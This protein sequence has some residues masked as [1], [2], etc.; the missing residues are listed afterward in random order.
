MFLANVCKMARNKYSN[1]I[2]EKIIKEY[3]SGKSQINLSEKYSIPKS[4]ICR[5]VKFYKSTKSFQ[6]VHRGGRPRKTT[7]LEDSAIIKSIKKDPFIS[8]REIRVQLDLG[9]SARTIRRRAVD[10]GLKSFKAVKKPFISTKNKLARLKFAHDQINW[11]VRKWRNVLF[12]DES[13]FNF[14]GS[15]GFRRVRRPA[16]EALNP[17]YTKAT[18]KRGGGNVM[19][20]G[21]FS[22]HGLGPIHKIDGTMDRFMY[23]D[24]LQ[25]VMLP[26]AE[27]QLPLKWIFQ[28][29]NDPKH[30]SNTVRT[31]FQENR[32][33]VL[34]W[35][36]QSPDLNPIENLWEIVD[37]RI[38]RTNCK[39]KSDLFEQIKLA[40][41]RIPNSIINNL[42]DSMP[43]RCAE[44][45]KNKGFATKY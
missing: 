23:R 26:H 22:G 7:E 28:Q 15:D 29:D 5:L 30:T 13:K 11:T 1:E 8:S 25:S 16:K 12:S 19:V 42:I 6:T 35:P 37:R 18:V 32:I 21:Y 14:K 33:D 24:I 41:E 36:A 27:D 10:G 20:W 34:Q 2:K 43:R 3:K 39:N 40:W 38:V 17:R 44:V 31:W 4:V 9:V 45:I